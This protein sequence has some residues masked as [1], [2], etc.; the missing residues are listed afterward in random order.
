MKNIYFKF[1]VLLSVV[2]GQIVPVEPQPDPTV[3]HVTDNYYSFT[4]ESLPNRVY[5][6]Q[7]SSQHSST[8]D[9]SWEFIPD[10][11]IGDGNP[12]SMGFE[13]N[14]ENSEFFRL[15]YVDN[16]PEVDPF[17]ADFDGDGYTNIEEVLNNKNS[18]DASS[19]PESGVSG[20]S[21]SSGGSNSTGGSGET[22][23]DLF[24][25]TYRVDEF[26]TTSNF[27]SENLP[28]SYSY[29]LGEDV[30]TQLIFQ[31]LDGENEV[32]FINVIPNPDFD[33]S[34]D[35]GPENPVFNLAGV[36]RLS[37][38]SGENIWK[39]EAPS[40]TEPLGFL[41]PITLSVDANR[42]SIVDFV[43]EWTTKDEPYEFWVNNDHDFGNDSMGDDAGP[44]FL[45]AS[46]NYEDWTD[47]RINQ[48]RD[49]EDFARIQIRIPSLHEEFKNGEIVM[50]LKFDDEIEEPKPS[51][52]FY[53]HLDG[54]GGTDYVDV[55][56]SALNHAG[57]PPKNFDPKNPGA[58]RNYN[59]LRSLGGSGEG[60]E[61]MIETS[62]WAGEKA[63]GENQFEVPDQD[64]TS[65][66][67][68]P[69]ISYSN[70]TRYMLFEG[71]RA[72]L[73]KLVF[74]ISQPGNQGATNQGA[75]SQGGDVWIE[76][77]D[78]NKMYEEYSVGDISGKTWEEINSISPTEES[79]GMNQEEVNF[80]SQLSPSQEFQY[81]PINAGSKNH[82]KDYILF[83]H[84]WRM[85]PSEKAFFA[86][87]S[88]KR[89]WH[90]GYR[91]RFG[92][93]LWPTEWTNR[94]DVLGEDGIAWDVRNYDRSDR[95]AYLS[96]RALHTLLKELNV[97]YPGRVRMFAH[98]MG[99]VVASQALRIEAKVPEP[100]E[101]VQSYIACQAAT[102][103]S[104]YDFHGPRR[105]TS[106][107]I[108]NH[109][110][111]T[112]YNG[113]EPVFDLS[114]AKSSEIPDLFGRYFEGGDYDEYFE[115]ID[116]VVSGNIANFHNWRDD[117]LAAWMLG[118]W[119]KP[120]VG[121]GYGFDPHPDFGGWRSY[122]EPATSAGILNST[123]IIDFQSPGRWLSLSTQED[124]FEIF[125]HIAEAKT[126][127]LG[128]SVERDY[129]TG[130]VVSV[131]LDTRK[132]FTV[133]QRFGGASEDH[134]AQFRSINMERWQFWDILLTGQAFFDI[135]T[136]YQPREWE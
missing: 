86:E 48:L 27:S 41:Y 124:A 13:A 81:P 135:E 60:H 105:L 113:V 18:F 92:T 38:K 24:S 102:V 35:R 122:R 22:T 39:H 84:G 20:S 29:S 59:G 1:L 16:S 32:F 70:P 5:F 54:D 43:G 112:Y 80:Y 87:T 127:A 7:V 93:F 109:P 100:Q 6:M 63:W 104:A 117:A 56:N 58:R 26:E 11:R 82:E 49:I 136:D 67:M 9:F 34:E 21:G 53:Y 28:F 17:L 68:Y 90:R 131:D 126:P 12:L 97:K 25:I 134:S 47:G 114:A 108:K 37:G 98:S 99:N 125:A 73:G 94:D 123:T 31:D 2:E 107:Y 72:G 106:L 65:D 14:E 64:A 79:P 61:Y 132:A 76:I 50:R 19:Y 42:D 119:Q 62:F 116:T 101:V 118:Q 33:L 88:F 78:M 23:T 128:A 89:L 57:V 83:V 85:K 8:N 4:W 36:V 51:I 46:L 3:E 91:G 95:K 75:T 52:V 71:A 120:D 45:G 129:R 66:I 133:N 10:I 44:E 130:N 77:K 96:G 110:N 69:E 74:D 15:V 30:V 55:K 115:N 121:W 40:G 111:V 103:A